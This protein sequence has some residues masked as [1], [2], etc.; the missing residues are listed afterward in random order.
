M[1]MSAPD[2]IL[3][4][5]GRQWAS[6]VERYAVALSQRRQL[7]G[8]NLVRNI[9]VGGNTIG[10]DHDGVDLAAAH[11]VARHVVG[12]Q[13]DGNPFLNQFP[14]RQSGSLQERPGLVGDDRNTLAS[15]DGR[16]DDAK[17]R[18]VAGRRQGTGIA[19]RER[20]VPG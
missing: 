16:T 9:A 13:G 10:A 14:R 15:L 3:P 12:N 4:S 5:M 20:P 11:Q 1:G 17:R 18:T 7:V 2:A 19:V 6:D 8:A